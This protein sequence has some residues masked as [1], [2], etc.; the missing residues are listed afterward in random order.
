MYELYMLIKQAGCRLSYK[1]QVTTSRRVS[2]HLVYP[3]FKD[4]VLIK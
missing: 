1:N 2:T 3:S 4:G